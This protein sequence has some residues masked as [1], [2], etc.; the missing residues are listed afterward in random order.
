MAPAYVNPELLRTPGGTLWMAS[1][2]FAQGVGMLL[3]LVPAKT[4]P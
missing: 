4:T 1:P 2:G 3:A